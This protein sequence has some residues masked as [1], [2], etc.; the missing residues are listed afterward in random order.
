[1]NEHAS[2]FS[3][4][5]NCRLIESLLFLLSFDVLFLIIAKN[6]IVS[7]FLSKQFAYL[8]VYVKAPRSYANNANTLIADNAIAFKVF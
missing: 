8:A 6:V 4:A 1:M 5:D 7:G 2:L 3:A